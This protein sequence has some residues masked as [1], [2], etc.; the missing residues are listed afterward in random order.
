MF[1]PKVGFYGELLLG[2]TM[3]DTNAY[4]IGGGVALRIV[5]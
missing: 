2:D 1:T 3:F 4:E 5:Y